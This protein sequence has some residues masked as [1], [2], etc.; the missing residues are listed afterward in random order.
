MPVGLVNQDSGF[1]NITIPSQAFITGLQQINT[2]THMLKL[3]NATSIADI[4][5]EIQN[6]KIDG[7]IVIPSNFS[8]SIMN[9]EQG[10]LIIIT[11]QSNPTVSA[12]LQAALSGDI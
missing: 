8:A 4:K 9:G 5:A 10:T 11:D 7:G 12:E 1:N 3:S 6:S 2:Q